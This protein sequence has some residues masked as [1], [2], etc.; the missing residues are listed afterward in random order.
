[1]RI[2]QVAPLFERV[3]PALYGGTERVVAW[4]VDALVARGHAVTLFASG[5]SRTRAELVAACPRALRLDADI[6]DAVA[7]HVIELGQVFECADE[8]DIIHCH[9]DYLAYPFARLVRTPTAHTLHGRLDLTHLRPLFRHF[10]D[11]PLISISASQRSPVADL[12]LNW[13]ATVHHGLPLHAYSFSARGGDYLAFL[14]RIS[15]EKRLDLAIAVA[16]RV[17]IRLRVAAKVDPV[18]REYFEREIAPLLDNPLVDF[19]GEIGDAEKADFLGNA[20]ALIFPIDWPEP[21]G[22]AMIEA[23]AC[24]TPVIARPCGAVREIVVPGETGL[25]GSTVEELARAVE[26]VDGIDRTACRRHA[27]ARWSAD[28][29]AA[30][31]ERVFEAQAR[32][33]AVR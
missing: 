24:G 8:F 10:A 29:M 21:F 28:R 33:T 14:G 7:P 9:V 17:G 6:R 16:S 23:L 30:D 4:L 15:P 19:R 18:D 25:L 1:M 20:R 11:T 31:Y 27:E 32:R 13:V 26:L 5:D 22:L 3:P 12:D 2:A